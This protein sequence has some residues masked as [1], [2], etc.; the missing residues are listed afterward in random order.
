MTK[1]TKEL[2]QEEREDLWEAY[3]KWLVS[4]GYTASDVMYDEDGTAY[5][6]GYYEDEGSERINVP[7][8]YQI[9]A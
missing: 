6:I 1:E 7:D 9:I 2:T 4:R 5:V 3:D 8:E